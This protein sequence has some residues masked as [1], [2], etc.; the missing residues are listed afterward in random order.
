LV[1]SSTVAKVAKTGMGLLGIQM[2]ERM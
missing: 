2:P 1:L